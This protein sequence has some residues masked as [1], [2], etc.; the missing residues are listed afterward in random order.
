M[1]TAL[2]AQADVFLE[3]RSLRDIE[4]NA[5]VS[6]FLRHIEYH[7]GI[8]FLTTNR[9][10][11]FDEAFLSRFHVALHFDT[12]NFEIKSSIWQSFL[13]KVGSQLP[14][15]VFAELAEKNLNGRQIK[16][17]CQTASSLALSRGEQVQETHLL[18][19]LDAMEQL[20]HELTTTQDAAPAEGSRFVLGRLFYGLFSLLALLIAFWMGWR[21]GSLASISR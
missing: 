17:A 3:K 20:V 11:T 5:V 7:R 12:L 18:E 15:T 21:W 6:V 16:N 2:F 19:A 1:L 8:L 13:K 10:A 9:V 4:R 14:D